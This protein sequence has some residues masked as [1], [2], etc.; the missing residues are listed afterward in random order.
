MISTQGVTLRWGATA[1]A[2][3]KVVDIKDFPDIGGAPELLETTTL[4]DSAQTFIHGI[5][6]MGAMEFTCNYTEATFQTVSTSA[7]T[8]LFYALEFGAAGAEGSFTWQGSHSVWLVGAG[9]NAVVDMRI[10]I[11]PATR[12]VFTT[13]P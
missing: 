8:P 4:T 12:P 5:Q 9:V 6:T 7:G 10:S 2:M 13:T 11:A 1:L 3:T